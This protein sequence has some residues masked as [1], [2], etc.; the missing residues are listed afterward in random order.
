MTRPRMTSPVWPS[1][2]LLAVLAGCASSPSKLRT[3]EDA[4]AV[5]DRH[6]LAA[7]ERVQA[8]QDALYQ[9][10]AINQVAPSLATPVNDQDA[11][12]DFGWMGDAAELLQHLSK[13]R[14][15]EFTTT[16]VKLP[17]PISISVKRQP[18]KGVLRLVQAQVAYRATV[19]QTAQQLLLQYNPPQP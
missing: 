19:T 13:E 15:L 17:L 1:L 6:I 9:A 11:L 14:G 5:V 16:G 2:T 4:A 3:S 7:V 18:L 8:S 10:G 12:M